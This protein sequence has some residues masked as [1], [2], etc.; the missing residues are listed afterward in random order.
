M[1]AREFLKESFLVEKLMSQGGSDNDWLK[2]KYYI[3]FFEGILNNQVYS[4]GVGGSTSKKNPSSPTNFMGIVQNPQDVVA[5]MKRAIKNKDFSDV[6]FDVEEVDDETL[7]P[8]GEIWENV[9]PGNIFKDEKVSGVLKPNMGNVSEAILGCAVAAKF[10]NQGGMITEAQVVNLAKQLAKNRGQLNLQAGKDVLE[11][12][13]TIPFM[14]KKAFYAWLN[15]DSRGKTLKDY[16]VPDDSI[17]MFD[18]RLKSAIEYANKSKKILSAVSEA[19]DDPGKNKIDVISDG[20]EK[21]NQNTTKVDLKILIDG[22]ETAK[23]LL[24]VKAGNVEQFGQAGGHNFNNLNEFFT[25]IVGLGLP[26]TFR[27]KFHEIP[28]QAPAEWNV[29]KKEN[30][31]NSFA[32]SYEFIAKQLSIQAKRDPDGFVENVYRGLLNHLTRNE[33]GVEMVILD[34][35]SKK[36]FSELEFGKDFEDALRQLQLVVDFRQATGY[37]LSVYGLPKTQLASK[38]IPKKQ[39]EP[40]RLIDLRSQ[41]DSRTNAIRNRINMG[42]LLKKIADIENYLEKNPED[43]MQQ[44]A[45]VSMPVAKAPVA[46][47]PVATPKQPALAVSKPKIGAPVQP[48]GTLGSTPAP[49]TGIK[50]GI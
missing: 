6:Y 15:E 28:K 48:K 2:D 30:F 14:D 29:K 47:P 5:Q 39:G 46:K 23:R 8:N 22:K 32:V 25:S 26:E 43:T 13:V 9:R 50:P 20:A 41:Y 33:A 42:P 12:K 11:F 19:V 21:E 31:E 34:P 38:F 7:E 37:A 27:K 16:K 36:A 18:Q 35:D 10:S 24:S 40:T 45:P 3:L 1:R 44:P 4:F 17:K 49:Q